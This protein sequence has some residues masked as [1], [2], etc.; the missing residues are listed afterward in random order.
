MKQTY[1][2][3]APGKNQ[4]GFTLIE[5]MVVVMI[6][7]IL[8]AVGYPSY[9]QYTTKARRAAAQSFMLSVAN[10]QEQII[11]DMRR[12]VAVSGNIDFPNA[13][14][15]AAPGVNMPVPADVASRYDII[16]ATPTVSTYTITARLKPGMSD[17]ACGTT[18]TLTET[19]S[20]TPVKAGC[21]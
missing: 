2:S 21:W 6:V 14:T 13:P 16:V 1:F 4:Q 15:A 12:Y 18:L 19:G 7:A 20:K 17:P 11:L 10:K 5:L 3:V 8:A 9:Q